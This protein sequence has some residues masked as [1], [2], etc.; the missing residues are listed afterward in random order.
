MN[1]SNNYNT[2][3]Q[4]NIDNISQH[5]KYENLKNAYKQFIEEINKSDFA[6]APTRFFV[7]L[8]MIK[9]IINF[10]HE[11]NKDNIEYWNAKKDSIVEKLKSFGVSIKE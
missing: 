9:D 3:Q 11:E 1:I 8:Q 10:A 7:E 2:S 6:N 5:S 4:K